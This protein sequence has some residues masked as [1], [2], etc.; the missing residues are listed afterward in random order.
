MLQSYLIQFTNWVLPRICLCCG[1]N[2]HDP[3]LDLCASCKNNLPWVSNRCYACCRELTNI[4]DA[5]VCDICRNNLPV[6]NRICALFAYQPPVIKLVTQ[7]KFSR[8]LSVGMLMA[9]LLAEAVVAQWYNGQQLPQILIPVP[10][11]KLRQR[12][13]G[14]NQAF[15]ICKPLAKILNIP[16]GAHI[17]KRVKHT[18]RQ[19]R[20]NRLQRNTNLTK[21]FTAK[22]DSRYKHIAI[23]DDVV[24]TGS[25]VR[26]MCVV[27]LRAGVET[28]DIWCVARA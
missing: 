8:K 26:A 15:E 22:I 18:Q 16:L 28:I 17:C 11:H 24:T 12:E 5:M 13:R 2:S 23:V 1:F 14:Y 6:F 21:A 25:T 3:H 4:N 27:L 9:N 10:L 7:L 19:S 20:L